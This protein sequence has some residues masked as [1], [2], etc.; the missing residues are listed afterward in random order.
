MA[1]NILHYET[2]L[3]NLQIHIQIKRT[4]RNKKKDKELFLFSFNFFYANK[5]SPKIFSKQMY[6]KRN[7][8]PSNI[9]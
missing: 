6:T 2:N 3:E 5:I 8:Q 9:R 7:S 4:K 1:K